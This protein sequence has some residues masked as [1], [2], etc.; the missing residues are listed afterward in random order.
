MHQNNM[1]YWDLNI[2]A[3]NH[4]F[5]VQ[6][7]MCSCKLTI[8]TRQVV[9]FNYDLCNFKNNQFEYIIKERTMSL[10]STEHSEATFKT[11]VAGSNQASEYIILT[12][13]MILNLNV[14]DLDNS[15]F[16]IH[17]TFWTESSFLSVPI[18]NGE[19]HTKH[20]HVNLS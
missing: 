15:L 18:S 20:I 1:L 5:I 16:R 7:Q 19:I 2:P 13:F 8:F 11:L 4:T 10:P 14:L 12:N 6:S 9:S 3:G 17:G